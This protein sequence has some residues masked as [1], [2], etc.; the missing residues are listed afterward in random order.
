MMALTN[1]IILC[2]FL[3]SSEA[4]FLNAI[5][6][7]RSWAGHG[8]NCPDR[9]EK[10]Q[11]LSNGAYECAS[12]G[13]ECQAGSAGGVL[14]YTSLDVRNM[15]EHGEGQSGMTVDLKPNQVFGCNNRNLCDPAPM[16][17]K[18]CFLKNNDGKKTLIDKGN[19]PNGCKCLKECEGDCDADNDCYGPSLKC[20]HRGENWVT[21]MP[22]TCTG[23]LSSG[24]FHDYCYDPNAEIPLIDRGDHATDLNECEGDCDSD[25]DCLDNLKCWHSSTIPPGCKG[26]RTLS[27]YDYC[28]DPSKSDA[29]F[30]FGEALL[31]MPKEQP[32]GFDWTSEYG[33]Y[34]T[35]ASLLCLAINVFCSCFFCCK[36]RQN[37]IEKA[38]EVKVK[39]IAFADEKE[40][41]M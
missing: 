23:T 35:M 25:G 4:G 11:L 30:P 12:E 19:P 41:M 22:G 13:G 27:W 14:Y 34:A 24:R 40:P 38:A 18:A 10:I 2:A 26:K 32:T 31:E 3:S 37:P 15:D 5:N 36:A 6:E 17:S 21:R 33:H 39:V 1:L 20:F 7:V 16:R 8:P 9:F 29:S 28:Y